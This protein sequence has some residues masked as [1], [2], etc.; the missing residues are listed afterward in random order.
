[1]SLSVWQW[2]VCAGIA[3]A[4]VMAPPVQA[5]PLEA[6]DEAAASVSVIEPSAGAEGSLPVEFFLPP[7]DPDAALVNTVV[8]QLR[9]LRGVLR[10][11]AHSF[12]GDPPESGPPQDTVVTGSS[13]DVAEQLG[14]QDPVE[15]DRARRI[16]DRLR[17]ADEMLGGVIGRASLPA[18][19]VGLQGAPMMAVDSA[20]AGPSAP[21]SAGS[22]PGTEPQRELL[23]TVFVD[24][25]HW[26]RSEPAFALLGASLLGLFLW[27]RHAGNRAQ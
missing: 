15:A 10:R 1:M 6:A 24:L 21:R 18:P 26:L 5:T 17:D 25:A 8:D 14:G 4:V 11:A 23:L 9:G 3:A 7:A 22:S 2:G 20:A 19:E 27:V 13:L 16:A 12:D